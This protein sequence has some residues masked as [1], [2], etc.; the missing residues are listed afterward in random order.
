MLVSIIYGITFTIAKDVMPKYVE[1]FG[2]ILLRVG[3]SV[4]LF[5]L[6]NRHSNNRIFAKNL[7]SFHFI[8]DTC[9]MGFNPTRKRNTRPIDYLIVASAMLAIAALV[10]WAFFG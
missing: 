7:Q 8:D 1:P 5:W 2:F 3:G 10:I 6:V 4:F 9:H